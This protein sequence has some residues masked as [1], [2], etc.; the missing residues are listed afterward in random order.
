MA[1][2]YFNV[3]KLKCDSISNGINTLF[4]SIDQLGCVGLIKL[5]FGG[6]LEGP[7]LN[8]VQVF[9]LNHLKKILNFKGCV[10]C[11]NRKVRNKC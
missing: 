7:H 9:F 1:K 6:L 8:F 2:L 11:P 5:E 4:Y 3:Q 10:M